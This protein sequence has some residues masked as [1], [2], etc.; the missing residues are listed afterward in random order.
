[1]RLLYGIARDWCRQAYLA[2]AEIF[3]LDQWEWVSGKPYEQQWYIGTWHTNLLCRVY[4]FFG[5]RE[6]DA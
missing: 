3:I 5:R 2:T 1:M 4:E 6:K